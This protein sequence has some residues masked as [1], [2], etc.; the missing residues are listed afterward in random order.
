VTFS[1]ERLKIEE[2]LPAARAFIREHKLNETIAGDLND[3]GI[4]IMGGLTNSVLRALERMGLA[5]VFGA[6]RVPLLVINVVYPLV[7][8]EIREFCAGKRS[9]SRLRV[10][11]S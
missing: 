5:D 9:L 7:P 3:I 2:R 10:T 4:I 11:A 6:S 8:E 1:Q